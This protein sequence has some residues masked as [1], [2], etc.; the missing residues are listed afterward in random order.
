MEISWKLHHFPNISQLIS[1]ILEQFP[2][3]GSEKNQVNSHLQQ[4]SIV[5]FQKKKYTLPPSPTHA[6]GKDAEF[7]RG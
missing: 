6:P 4:T 2:T 1:N 5:H 7:T 3:R